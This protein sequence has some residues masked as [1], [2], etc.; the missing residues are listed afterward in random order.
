MF[1]KHRIYPEYN[2][3]YLKNPLL[4]TNEYL[5][6]NKV[7]IDEGYFANLH[8]IAV[9]V[10]D[11]DVPTMRHDAINVMVAYEEEVSLPYDLIQI[12]EG[13][14][15]CKGKTLILCNPF[16]VNSKKRVEID[17]STFA[18]QT[19]TVNVFVDRA[20]DA[21]TVFFFLTRKKQYLAPPPKLKV[22]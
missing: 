1:I 12:Y 13:D 21:A 9:I 5:D 11:I 15:L 10:E 22:F 17:V 20:V 16:T 19:V 3:I 8:E 14:F 6:W 18:G 4:E 7:N 2:Q